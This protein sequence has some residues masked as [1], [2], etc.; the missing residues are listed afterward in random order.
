MARRF[1]IGVGLL[2]ALSSPAFGDTIVQQ[3]QAVD[4]KIA[5]LNGNL[6]QVQHAQSA[7][8]VEVN[9]LSDRIGVLESHV[10]YVAARLSILREDLALRQQRL[11]KL[12]QLFQLQTRRVRLLRHQYRV[13][14]DRLNQRL[15][16]IFES[17]DPT[18][19]DVV[20]G[21]TSIE[22]ALDQAHF[23]TLIGEQDRLIATQVA[24]AQHAM[25][26]ARRKT[27]ALRARVDGEERA[28][29]VRENQAQETKS[30]LEGAKTS[31][32]STKQ[33]RVQKLSKLS[34]A[35]QALADEITQEQAAAAQL[36]AEIRAAQSHDN[37]PTATPSSAGLI[38]PVNGPITSPFGPRW[39]SFHPGID[40]GVPTGTP[41]HAAA[42]GK[43]IYCGWEQGYGNLVV[44]DNGNN[45]ATA[46]AHQSAIAVTCGEDVAQGQVIGYTGCTG[47]CTGPHLH[48]EVRINGNPVDPLGYLVVRGNHVSPVGP[49]LLVPGS[50]AASMVRSAAGART[51]LTRTHGQSP[52]ARRRNELGRKDA[53]AARRPYPCRHDAPCS[54]AR[55]WVRSSR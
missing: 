34:A 3:K 22:A 42:A 55:G 19:L 38:W 8:R 37:G 17:N 11:L 52:Y 2:F 7:L 21:S 12:D 39:G 51:S 29:Q 28:L 6:A 27:A 25:Q 9:S 35:E 13:A 33:Q 26:Q 53:R 14:V 4:S 10:G 54:V 46:Y 15:L 45:L 23:I 20:L 18:T 5:A 40:I 49:L 50:P 44:L 48:F 30:A 24:G 16:N 32:D 31:L 1:L 36:G 47:L 43:V 41:I